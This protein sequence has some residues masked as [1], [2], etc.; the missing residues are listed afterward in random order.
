METDFAGIRIMKNTFQSVVVLTG[1]GISAES[2]LRT[3]RASDGLWE[4]H[5]VEEV[6]TPEAFKRNPAL[7]QRFYNQRRAQLLDG[8][9]PN[10]GHQ[11][12][13]NFEQAFGGDFTLITQNIDN[14]HEQAGSKNIL[15]MHG[16]LL[17]IRC[18]ATGRIF[19][20][21]EALEPERHCPC[22]GLPG[23]LRPHVVWFGEMPLYM[24]EIEQALTACDLFV[25]IGT[26]GNVYPAAGFFQMAKARGAHTVELNLEPSLSGSLFDEQHY[27]PGTEVVPRYFEA[28]CGR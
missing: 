24:D 26:S 8:V 20:C 27:G 15:H 19:P 17:C 25:S 1:A 16:E 13:A 7:V 28:V 12:L 5:R 23:Q 6:A 14:L 11:A 10:A 18:A 3:F 2:G 22:C 9:R 4:D 21:R